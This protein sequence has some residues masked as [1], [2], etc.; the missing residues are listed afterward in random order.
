MR[1]LH[2]QQRMTFQSHLRWQLVLY[3]R[4]ILSFCAAVNCSS[5]ATSRSAVGAL[6]RVGIGFPDL[7]FILPPA[8]LS[9]L[10][11]W[12]RLTLF[13]WSSPIG[14]GFDQE[15]DSSLIIAPF[16]GIKISGG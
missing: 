7:G 15:L 9:E 14:L 16:S 12:L 13:G 6:S 3:R 11:P 2:Q 10:R 5:A 4:L 8:L 1:F